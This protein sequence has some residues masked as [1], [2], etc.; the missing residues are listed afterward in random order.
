MQECSYEKL[1]MIFIESKR[2]LDERFKK[3]KQAGGVISVED[4][5]LFEDGFL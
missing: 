1:E 2:E 5:R 4:A 3:S